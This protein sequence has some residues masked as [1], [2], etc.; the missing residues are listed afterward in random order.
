M[1]GSRTTKVREKDWVSVEKAIRKLNAAAAGD[2]NVA[3][4][5]I[6]VNSTINLPEEAGGITG[7]AFEVVADAAARLALIKFVSRTCYQSD[8]GTFWGYTTL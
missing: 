1:A 5:I 4:R 8:E 6:N 3:Y 2:T 7:S